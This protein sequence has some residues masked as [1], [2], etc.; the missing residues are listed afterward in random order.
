MTELHFGRQSALIFWTM[1]PPSNLAIAER[2]TTRICMQG[3]RRDSFQPPN[4]FQSVLLNTCSYSHDG[5]INTIDESSSRDETCHLKNAK[6]IATRKS[7]FKLLIPQSK[8]YLCV[9]ICWW[10]HWTFK[11]CC[12]P[13]AQSLQH[14]AMR[15]SSVVTISLSMIFPPLP[16]LK[17]THKVEQCFWHEDNGGIAVNEFA[18]CVQ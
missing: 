10:Q 1:L 17:H 8:N 3:K 14:C 5:K 15:K 7:K 11:L 9:N 6:S 16:P 12:F 13:Q 18:S 2:Q 4:I